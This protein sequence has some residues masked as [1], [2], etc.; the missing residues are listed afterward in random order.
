[1]YYN[2]SFKE[3]GDERGAP[4]EHEINLADPDRFQFGKWCERAQRHIGEGDI[5]ASYSSDRIGI[6]EPIRQPFRWKAAFWVNSGRWYRNH[7]QRI[8]AYQL[9]PLDLFE[10]EA[11]RYAEIVADGDAARRSPLGFYH[12]IKVE[13][14]GKLYVLIGKP[15]IFAPSNA[16]QFSLF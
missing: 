8:E 9:I 12:G 1:M 4:S 16:E 14:G 15:Q 3:C 5:S 2:Y 13:H 7:E 6:G 11:R 10:G